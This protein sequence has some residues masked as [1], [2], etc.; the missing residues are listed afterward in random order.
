MRFVDPLL[1]L[2]CGTIRRQLALVFALATGLVMFGFGYGVVQHQSAFLMEQSKNNAE[3][4]AHMLAVGSTAWLVAND[5]AGLQMELRSIARNPSLKYA[6]VLGRDGRVYASNEVGDIGL[7][8][9]DPVS[10][11]LLAS[12]VPKA[13]VL[14]DD[15]NLV[16]AAEPVFAGSR[17]LG[18]VRIG[19]GRASLHENL[20]DV[21]RR[22]Y[23][24]GA[25]AIAI[26]VLL[27]MLIAA[28]LTR[29]LRKLMLVADAVHKGER[30]VRAGLGRSDEIGALGVSINGMLD[31]LAASERDRV[32]TEEE[33]RS[34]AFYDALTR[35]PNRRMLVERLRHAMLASA[36]SGRTGA[37]LFIDLDN[38]KTLNDTRGHDMGDLL[39]QQVSQ[40]LLGCVR[41]GDTVSRLGGD[42]FV[43]ML[44]ALA[45]AVPEA[46][47]QA[48]AIGRKILTALAVP[49]ELAG[50]RHQSTSSIGITLF[51]GSEHRID[52]LMKRADL[53]MYEAKTA[54][55]NTLRFF[56]PHMQTVVSAR[57]ALEHD[58][59]EG[60]QLGQFELYYQSQRDMNGR[61]TGAEALLR[62][63]HPERGL[64]PPNDF[65]PLTE[66]T[67]LIIPL[68]RWVLET[69]CTQLAAWGRE[70]QAAHL[71]VAVNISVR[72]FRQNDFV[73]Q[74][75]L[76]L[77]SSGADPRHLKLELTESLLMDDVE[78]IIEKMTTLKRH[79]VC[80]SLDDFGTGYSS[81][82][83]LKRLPLDQLKIDRSFVR[84]VTVDANDAAIASTIVALAHHMGLDV[85]AEGVETAAQADFLISVG[86]C[87]FQG[88]LYGP[89]VPVAQ[90]EQMLLSLQAPA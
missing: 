53:A 78:A 85:I 86:C 76:A 66:D 88:Y 28:G 90:F 73:E 55:R 43:V 31:A 65:I 2:A 7:M 35:L 60:L 58:L 81:L 12:T 77:A 57:A 87:A 5:M 42:E 84:D 33:I 9:S 47:A 46:A 19:W 89:P 61:I 59:R 11:R 3:D 24:L 21:S 64:V 75:L 54:G 8:V 49:Y 15:A 30:S 79:G 14:V 22:G 74:V 25:A 80:F 67:G 32:A 26:A 39:L 27:S 45:Q 34:L 52:E 56:D 70:E 17:H 29:S 13:A 82:S 10:L 36:R 51:V 38:F 4:L 37:L 62:W 48:E 83:Y 50:Q 72:Q 16:D 40:R 63:T 1:D 41:E 69:A 20:R 44:E 18:W 68:G 23:L 6:M 71:S